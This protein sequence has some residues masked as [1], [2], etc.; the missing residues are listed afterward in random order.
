MIVFDIE[1]ESLCQNDLKKIMPPWD[2][3]SIGEHPGAFD[4]DSVKL[5]NIK[6][7]VKI[8]EKKD[9][10]LKKFNASVADYYRKLS[11]GEQDYW[12][13]LEGKGALSAVTGKVCA[14]GYRGKKVDLHLAVDGV[15][16][17]SLLIRFWK[18][19]LGARSEGRNMIGFNIFDFDLPF[20]CQRS[21]INGVDVP[22]TVFT[23]SGYPEPLFIDL[24]RRWKCGSKS[25]ERGHA[26][27]DT[28]AKSLG[29]PGKPVGITGEDFAKLL[30]S[31]AK[32]DRDRAVGYLTGDLDLA[33]EIGVRI[34]SIV[35]TAA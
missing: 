24:Y 15:S 9:E 18:T 34:G 35:S 26:T 20:L 6:D 16:E 27:L 23:P 28:V 25:S 1:T 21:W 22:A 19:Y 11:T 33:F 12:A 8:Q 30:R 17:R 7:P 31:P 13:A 29:L 3:K 32:N 10:A 2:P 5:G 4:E 14:I